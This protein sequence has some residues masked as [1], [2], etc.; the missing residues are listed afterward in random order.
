MASITRGTTPQVELVV[1]NADYTEYTVYLSFKTP[2]MRQPIVKTNEQFSTFEYDDSTG[3]TLII[4]PLTQEE[5][6]SMEVGACEVQIRAIKEGGTKA[7]AT[8]VG[9]LTVERVIQE[10][11]LDGELQGESGSD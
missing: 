8:K 11:V 2:K 7:K 10:G 5:T 9:V 3:R 4:C 6:L 1:V